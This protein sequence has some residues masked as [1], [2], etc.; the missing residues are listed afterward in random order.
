[1]LPFRK[2][3][4]SIKNYI[5]KLKTLRA[6]RSAEPLKVIIGAATTRAQGWVSTNRDTL[7]LLKPQDWKQILNDKPIHAVLAEHVWEHLTEAEGVDAAKTCYQFL[8]SGGY[9]RAAVPD[10]FFPDQNYIE[11]VKPGGHGAGSDDHKVLYTYE[12]FS[13]VFKKAGFQVTLLEYFDEKGV[14]H[15]TTWNREQGMISRSKKFDA[16][17]KSGV[18]QYSSIIIDAVKL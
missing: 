3:L 6:L 15:E 18:I 4:S 14:F 5:L 16:R 12:S 9:V 7:D 2:K 13:N 1:M 10:G 8:K 17:N 11:Y